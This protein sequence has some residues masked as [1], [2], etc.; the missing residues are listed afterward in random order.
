MDHEEP[1]LNL[2]DVVHD[3]T[4]DDDENDGDDA[5]S[6]TSSEH[7]VH[8]DAHPSGYASPSSLLSNIHQEFHD[9]GLSGG[10]FI[11]GQSLSVEMLEREIATLLNQNASAASAAL[12]NAAA[13]QRQANL[14]LGNDPE[15]A[16]ASDAAGEHSS[17]LSI[18]INGLAAVLQAAEHERV[19]DVLAAKDIIFSRQRQ[20]IAV[21]KEERNTRSAPAFHSLTADDTSVSHS[22]QRRE[23][24][25]GSEGSDYLYSDEEDEGSGLENGETQGIQHRSTTPSRS[26]EHDSF[27][28]IHP[29]GPN[30]LPDINDIIHNFSA[31]YGPE[32]QGGP[33]HVGSS[34]P[35]DS[36][37][38]VSF[39]RSGS[40]ISPI[41]HP[42]PASSHRD[43]PLQ[44]VAS[45]STRPSTPPADDPKKGRRKKDK[46]AGSNIH[47]CIH[48]ECAKSFSRRSDLARHMRI[49][50]GERPFVCSHPGCSKTFIQRSALHVHL[51]VHTGEKPHSCEYPDCGKTFGD[52]SSL[53][54]HRR[55]HTGKR[56]YKCEDPTCEKTFTRR[57]TLNQHMRTHDPSWEPDPHLKY[58]FKAKRLKTDDDAQ[59][60][61]ESVRAISALFQAG[62]SVTSGPEDPGE[63]LAAHVASISAEIAA[64]LAQ[65]HAR[66]YN[67]DDYEDDEDEVDDG[68]G[69]G[70]DLG[71]PET[72]G[73]NT[74]GIR[75]LDHENTPL[76]EKDVRGLLGDEDDDSDAFP[77]PL[78]TRKGKDSHSSM[79]GIKRKR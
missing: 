18:D 64:A 32:P 71:G 15:T 60:L 76:I 44:P 16:E 14:E 38:I 79:T 12:L 28:N 26:A 23:V 49:H 8:H 21:E 35:P 29:P 46:D 54:R 67:E 47:T 37:P 59:D 2:S 69:S 57:T 48:E 45:I 6:S 73:P 1:L 25:R 56:P 39:A 65:A 51:R 66:E 75:G 9:G 20:D 55:T 72:I 33:S 77:I 78:R 10:Q 43:F 70:Q 58:S 5:A 31:H 62:E 68:F 40:S 50:T 34:T 27:S 52:S 11:G 36:S 61:E 3:D 22:P 17:G 19:A 30:D 53:A 4:M 41:S 74:S 63:P 24:R 42:L 7:R 13:Q